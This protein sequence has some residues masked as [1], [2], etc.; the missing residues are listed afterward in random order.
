M[1]QLMAVHEVFIK[2]EL[3]STPSKIGCSWQRFA[4]SRVWNRS[5][6]LGGNLRTGHV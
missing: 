2:I 3:V 5:W 6:E 4:C 1:A